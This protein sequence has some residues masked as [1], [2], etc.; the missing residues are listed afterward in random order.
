MA[1]DIT[2]NGNA[3]AT[4]DV[5]GRQ[6][7]WIKLA[8]G[9]PDTAIPVQ[10]SGGSRLPINGTV[11]ITASLPSGDN[12][13]GNV[14]IVTMPS[15]PAG[16][17]N[18]GDVDIVTM[19]ASAFTTD[20]VVT[21]AD[22]SALHNGLT[23]L[24]P[25]RQVINQ[26]AGTSE[27]TAITAVA[28]KQLLVVGAYLSVSASATLTFRSNTA[29]STVFVADPTTGAPLTLPYMPVGWFVN[30]AGQ[31]LTIQPSASSSVRGVIVYVEV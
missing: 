13:I 17:N 14:D 28:S 27:F 1:D 31:S 3:I 6:Y 5:S 25:K 12:N 23:A 22:V 9:A 19:P 18:I 10:D 2:I 4:D 26:A 29:G 24:T 11:S 8:F 30:T 15:L 21:R 7:Q 16:G 20:G